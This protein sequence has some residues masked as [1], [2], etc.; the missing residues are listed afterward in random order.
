[1]EQFIKPCFLAALF[2]WKFWI[3]TLHEELLDFEGGKFWKNPCLKGKKSES[4]EISEGKER[5]SNE[6]NINERWQKG[7]SH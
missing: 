3:G 5:N 2:D 6:F 1:M 4:E 7:E